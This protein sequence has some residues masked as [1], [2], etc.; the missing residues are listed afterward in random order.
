VAVVSRKQTSLRKAHGFAAGSGTPMTADYKELILSDR[1][2]PRTRRALLG[3]VRLDQDGPTTAFLSPDCFAILRAVVDRLVPQ[4]GGQDHVDIAHALDSRTREKVGDGWRFA[5]MPSDDIAMQRGLA[6][7]NR[8]ATQLYDLPF[9]SLKADQQDALL[10]T[11]Q[12][13]KTAWTDLNAQHWFED[14]ITD[15]IEIYVSHPAALRALGFS[16][17]AFFP[18]WSDVRLNGKEDW[19]P[20][21][22]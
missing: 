4:M 20:V 14:L 19:E 5:D 16:G 22:E 8:S 12:N 11:V 15:S 18:R 6:A 7:L 10:Q 3:R 21:P 17:F 9:I 1:V 2:T 13:G